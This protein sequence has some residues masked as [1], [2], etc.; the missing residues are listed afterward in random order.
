[1]LEK[2]KTDDGRL[3]LSKR[4]AETLTRYLLEEDYLCD[5]NPEEDLL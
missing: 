5:H 4:A 1:M 2:L 3:V